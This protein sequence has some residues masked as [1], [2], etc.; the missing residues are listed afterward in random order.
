MVQQYGS[1]LR[2]YLQGILHHFNCSS[3]AWLNGHLTTGKGCGRRFSGILI[4]QQ[5]MRNSKGWSICNKWSGYR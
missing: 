2:D 5:H 1:F 3:T 4:V